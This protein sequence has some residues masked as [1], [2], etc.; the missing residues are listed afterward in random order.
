[1]GLHPYDYGDARSLMSCLHCGGKPDSKDHNPSRIFLDKNIRTGLDPDDL[2]VVG[3]C[4][5]CNSF[6]SVD[7][8]YL[9]CLVEAARTGVAE[10]DD[11]WRPKARVALAHN[12]KLQRILKEAKQQLPNETIWRVDTVRVD[13]VA[14]KL[15]VGHAAFE[16][17]DPP[18]C[19]P[20]LV[21]LFPL[22]TLRSAHRNHFETVPEL[23]G[24]PEVGSRALFRMFE[25]Y[26]SQDENGWIVIQPGRY[27]YMA[28][29]SGNLAMVRMVLS[30]YLGIEVIW[31]DG[32]PLE[33]PEYNP[34]QMS[35][36]FY[37][38]FS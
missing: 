33:A 31:N 28:V 27:R 18:Y 13:R 34:D 38:G 36:D 4:R 10:P 9:A 20:S 5:S 30:E 7:E 19:E 21:S 26:P 3:L 32:E 35:F 2:P 11:R 1:M 24:Y 6:F 15:A 23:P 37:S 14:R 16:L 29:G 17:H 25:D 22:H 8:P 12:R